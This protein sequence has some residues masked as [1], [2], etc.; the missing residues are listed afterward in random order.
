MESFLFE[1]FFY[2]NL[3]FKFLKNSA[4]YISCCIRY[5][6]DTILKAIYNTC[7][8]GPPASSAVFG[9]SKIQFWKQFTTNEWCC[10]FCRLLYSVYQR[11]NFESNLQLIQS[12]TRFFFRCI[13]YIKDTILKAIYNWWTQRKYP[14]WAVFGISKIQFWKQFT[15]NFTPE[16]IKM[17]CIR[18]IK[19]TIL[20]A[21]Y[22]TEITESFTCI[23]VFGI[24]KI[25]FWKQFTTGF[26][27]ASYN[28]LLYSV[29]Q[30]YNFESNL[31]LR[32]LSFLREA[33]CIRYIKDTILKAIYNEIRITVI[34]EIAVFGISKI[35]FWKQFTTF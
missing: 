8:L 25:Q 10:R 28:R 15:T 14:S 29:Y 21:I 4:L 33:S 20:K 3:R 11:Y 17:R 1:Y 24:S 30:R 5:I 2:S 22:N 6:K 32:S 31:Q 35:Q 13:R 16:A 7:S 18:Y 23:A 34:K 19:D 9:I 27:E 26:S 12:N